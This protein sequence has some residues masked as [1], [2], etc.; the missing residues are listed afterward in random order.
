MV[1]I[2]FE[3]GNGNDHV[4]GYGTLT[5]RDFDFPSQSEIRTWKVLLPGAEI[6]VQ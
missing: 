6:W 3:S 4:F 2:I 5:F 1:K